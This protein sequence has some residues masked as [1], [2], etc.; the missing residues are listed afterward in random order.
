[1][2]PTPRGLKYRV[3]LRW[4]FKQGNARSGRS[5]RPLL[6]SGMDQV[7]TNSV[8]RGR[9]LHVKHAS[10][11]LGRRLRPARRRILHLILSEAVVC[12]FTLVNFSKHHGGFMNSNPGRLVGEMTH[13]PVRGYKMDVMVLSAAHAER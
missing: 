6:V 8:T 3:V 11:V 13:L 12:W 9:L 2:P 5:D 1:M 4:K 10:D 7:S